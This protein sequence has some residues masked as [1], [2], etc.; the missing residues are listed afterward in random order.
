MG[1]VTQYSSGWDEQ[2]V[3]KI[4][5]FWDREGLGWGH[6]KQVMEV[7]SANQLLAKLSKCTFGV[8]EVEY[9]GHVVLGE[10]VKANPNKVA[11]MLEW[12][13]PT[14]LKALQG[15]LGLMGYYKKFIMNYGL[16]VAPLTAL[17][18]KDAFTWSPESTVAFQ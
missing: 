6:F 17:L 16:I 18:K 7:L 5:C 2:A 15:F 9:L 3:W 12:P 1:A 8:P 13:T 14:N 11:F 10:G 4:N